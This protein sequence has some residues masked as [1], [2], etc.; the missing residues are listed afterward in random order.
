MLELLEN[1]YEVVIIDDLSNASEKAVM[2]MKQLS[3]QSDRLHFYKMDLKNESQIETIFKKYR[4]DGVIHFAGYKAVG[5]SVKNPLMYYENNLYSI[6]TILKLMKKYKIFNLVFSSSATVYEAT[7]DIPFHEDNPLN[8]SNPYGRT[9]QF[10]ERM[11]K[12]LFLSNANWRIICLRYFNPLGAHK[13]G[14]LGEDPNGIPNNLVPYIT[15]VA[16][17]KLP[18][19]NVF[20]TDYPTP[21]G[22]CVRDYV[23]VMDL[24]YGHKKALEYIFSSQEGLYEAINL[25]SGIGYSVFDILQG[26]EEVTGQSIP[27]KITERRPGDIPISLSDISKAATLLDWKPRSDLKEMCQDTWRW[28]KN[29]PNGFG[30]EE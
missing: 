8:A 13:S 3:K 18:Y 26:F 25:G 20:G 30:K 10:I 14:D 21:D 19:L 5:E 23:H 29:H 28:Q 24:A 12:D 1:D 16:V 11:L 15:Q 4:F 7:S 6:L 22:T 27:Y 2:T 17:G 9:K